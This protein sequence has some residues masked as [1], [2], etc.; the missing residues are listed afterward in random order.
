M[1]TRL[2]WD[3]SV[4]GYPV[5][6]AKFERS[7]DFKFNDFKFISSEFELVYVFSKERITGEYEGLYPVDRKVVLARKTERM[8]DIDLPTVELY[9]G[10]TTEQLLNLAYQSGKYSRFNRDINFVSNEFEKLYKIWIE[11]SISRKLSNK[12]FICSSRCGLIGFSTLLMKKDVAEIGLIAVDIKSRGK[13]IGSSLILNSV[14]Y[15]YENKYSQI[16]VTTQLENSKA[17]E[18][19]EKNGFE[20]IELTYV[21]HYWNR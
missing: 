16:Q 1:I 19:Y 17:I 10:E 2:E 5:G 12:V 14:N 11:K 20:I 4:F 21:Y 15:A 18:V 8:I 9:Q 3:S 7:K 13:G 6:K